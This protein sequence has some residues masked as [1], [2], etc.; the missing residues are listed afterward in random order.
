[1]TDH[2]CLLKDVMLLY[3]FSR[4]NRFMFLNDCGSSAI[5][6]LLA[7]W[8]ERASDYAMMRGICRVRDCRKLSRQ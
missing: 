1:M 4:V 2:G 7:A 6:I 8:M 3:F 5:L